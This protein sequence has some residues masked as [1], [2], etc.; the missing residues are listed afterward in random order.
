MESQ[1]SFLHR[2]LEKKLFNAHCNQMTYL[3]IAETINIEF[4]RGN[5]AGL[6]G[7]LAVQRI[8]EEFFN[9]FSQLYFFLFTVSNF[10]SKLGLI[11]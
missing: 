5:A 7:T 9:A 2:D 11:V 6:L 8:A 1:W 4:A 3:Y 10:F